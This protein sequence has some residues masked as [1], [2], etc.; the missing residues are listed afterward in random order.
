M[1]KRLYINRKAKSWNYKWGRK[2]WRRR[3]KA[4]RRKMIYKGYNRTY[5]VRKFKAVHIYGDNI[6]NNIV[7]MNMKNDEQNHLA[8]H[9]KEFKSK[10]RLQGS[11]LKGAKEDVLKSAMAFLKGSE[12]VFKAFESGIFLKPEQSDQSTNND[13]YT[14]LD[15]NTSSNASLLDFQAIQ[16]FHYLH[17]KRNRT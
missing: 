12:M 8:T 14:S 2:N 6:R 15:M 13:K 17:Q 3:K 10:R 7:N 1:N 9:I 16:T 4:D 5:N 11:N